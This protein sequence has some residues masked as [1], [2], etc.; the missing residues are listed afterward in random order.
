ME[1]LDPTLVEMLRQTRGIVA[2]FA[3]R[4]L[5]DGELEVIGMDERDKLAR[6][7]VANPRGPYKLGPSEP[8]PAATGGH[9]PTVPA[10]MI[11]QSGSLDLRSYV[12]DRDF[13][14]R[15]D[16]IGSGN[17]RAHFI[18]EHRAVL[19][20]FKLFSS[21]EEIDLR[22]IV[23]AAGRVVLNRLE[24]LGALGVVSLVVKDVNGDG[25]ADYALTVADN[26]DHLHIWTLRHDCTVDRL[27]FIEDGPGEDELV[28][29][30]V[31]IDYNARGRGSTIHSQMSEPVLRRTGQYWGVTDTAFRW[32]KSKNAFVIVHVGKWLE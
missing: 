4:G 1:P 18:L 15:S 31:F 30:P 23:E 32:D 19:R 21:P 17:C 28:G 24:T 2:P 29:I 22:I 10:L 3:W 7:L 5:M 11:R 20:S 26:S 6:V 13:P 16:I 8:Y 12:T 14:F 27:R 25:L 9:T